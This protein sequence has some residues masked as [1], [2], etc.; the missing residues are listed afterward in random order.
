MNISQG[1]SPINMDIYGHIC[2]S[3]IY[4]PSIPIQYRLQSHDAC[5]V[6]KKNVM[7]TRHWTEHQ[8]KLRCFFMHAI[9]NFEIQRTSN[10]FCKL[11][12]CDRR[13]RFDHQIK[14]IIW[15]VVSTNLKHIWQSVHNLRSKQW[16]HVPSAWSILTPQSQTS[17]KSNGTQRN[18]PIPLSKP[19]VYCGFHQFHLLAFRLKSLFFVASISSPGLPKQPK[20]LL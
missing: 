11:S 2:R 15:L 16:K 14:T 13:V 9:S 5:I 6:S 3:Y 20:I 10:D 18:V 4:V 8:Q 19:S 12:A 17:D 7:F 1:H